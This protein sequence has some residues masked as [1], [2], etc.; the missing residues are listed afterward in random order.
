M[1]PSDFL[2]LIHDYSLL[3]LDAPTPAERESIAVEIADDPDLASGILMLL[4]EQIFPL[5]PDVQEV[6]VQ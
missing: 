5:L 4:S 3:L 2:I 6:P 1:Q